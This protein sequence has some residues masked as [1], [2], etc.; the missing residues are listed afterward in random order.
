MSELNIVYRPLTDLRP[1]ERNPRD[2][3]KAVDAVA[4]SIQ[5]FGFL[6]PIIIV[7]EQDHTI[8]A[9]HT[10]YLA[11]QRLKLTEVP[12]VTAEDL[13]ENQ[14]RAFRLAD[15][16]VAEIA[17]WDLPLLDEAIADIGDSMDLEQFGFD[18]GVGELYEPKD[19]SQ[20]LD[21]D[22]FGDNTFDY[23]CPE[24]GFM[25]NEYD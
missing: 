9:G 15:N 16:R 12:T 6:V 3:A 2:N 1:Y 22:A 10:R 19:T 24:C 5:A 13:T 23:Q 4:A 11:A 20:E 14:I 8:V 7:S 17:V 18:L 25:F 21:T